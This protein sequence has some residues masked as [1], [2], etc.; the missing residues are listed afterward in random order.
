MPRPEPD[1]VIA[2]IVA[3]GRGVRAGGGT[4]KQYRN[5]G[6]KAILRRTAELFLGHPRIGGVVVVIHPD[7]RALYDEAIGDLE[8]LLPPLSG[9]TSRQESVRA[10]L[11]ALTALDAEHVLIHDAVRPFASA[12]LIDRVLDA[13]EEQEAALAASPVTDTLKRATAGPVVEST[14]AR[15]GLYA[16]ETPQGFR[17]AAIL[18]AHRRAAEAGIPVT[19]DASIAEWAGIAVHLVPGERTNAKLTTPEDIAI[20]DERLSAMPV[21]RE[22]RVGT[23]YDVHPFTEGEAVW[24]GGVRIPYDKRLAGHSDADVALHALTDA[25]LGAIADGDIGVHFPPSDPQWK[26]ASSDRFLAY[27]IERAR[28]RGAKIVHLDL[29]IVA[30]GPKIGPHR[31][32]MR[33]RIAEIAGIGIG[34]VGVKATT[35]EKLGFIGRGEGIA[36]IGTATLSLPA[37][38]E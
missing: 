12:A 38:D 37:S 25:V 22:T 28:A 8:G 11:E 13:L 26:G 31:D 7:D 17:F 21:L 5:I 29:A 18:D 32:A 2:L 15:E 9:G 4:P 6:G 10:G 30:E 34:R 19:D 33:A 23:G 36:A 27:A 20:A 24:L 1:R 16:A 35:N 3:A 14:V